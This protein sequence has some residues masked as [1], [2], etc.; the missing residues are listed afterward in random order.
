M[1][2]RLSII[3]VIVLFVL[4]LVW[5]LVSYQSDVSSIPG[6]GSIPGSESVPGT[7]VIP[8]TNPLSSQIE[9][10]ETL[11]KFITSL[12]AWAMFIVIMLKNMSAVLF[13]F[14]ASPVFLV[15]PVFS[16]VFN[17]WVIGVVSSQVIAEH[18]VGYLLAGLLPHGI[19]EIPAL[20][21]GEA[22]AF[23]FGIAIMQAVVSRNKRDQLPARL[24]LNVKYLVISL[25]LFVPAA[26]ME[27]FVTPLLLR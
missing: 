3:V 9:G 14:L 21:I 17:G 11:A 19:F 27:T 13:S 10:L 1:R 20:F 15:F 24:K 22:A 26:L 2:F 25:V 6:T 12:P 23:G 18:S 7:N 5:G 16:L 4:G 8:D